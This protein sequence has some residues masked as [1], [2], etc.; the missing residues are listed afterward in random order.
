MK[1]IKRHTVE[2]TNVF[3]KDMLLKFPVEH[4]TVV[5]AE[6]QTKGRG[7]MGTSWE[8]ETGKNLLFSLLVFPHPLKLTESFFL[9]HAVSLSLYE[10][11][12]R[13]QIPNLSIKWPN[14]LYVGD[15]K[16]GGILIENSY[17]SNIMKHAVIGVGLNVNQEVFSDLLPQAISMKKILGTSVNREILLAELLE[18][19]EEKINHCQPNHFDELLEKYTS[20][21]YRLEVPTNFVDADQKEFTG[22]IMGVTRQ[23][24]LRVE[25]ENK[26]LRNFGLKEIQ[27]RR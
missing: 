20:H 26:T 18:N 15:A 16:L 7:Q 27:M 2:S 5:T 17:R 13:R 6:T 11:L 21:L 10:V 24:K 14:D 8:S 19:M 12:Q 1:L 23:G 25:L 22:K 9:S 3:L 4:M